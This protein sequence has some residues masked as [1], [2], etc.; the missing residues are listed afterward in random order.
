MRRLGFL[1]TAL[2]TLAVAARAQEPLPGTS[3]LTL[4]GDLSAQMVAGI[5]RF[6]ENQTAA[7]A[8]ERASFWHRDLSSREAY[9]KSVAPNRERLRT[10]IGAVDAR[11]PVRAL[12]FVGDKIGRA[13]V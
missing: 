7:A 2:S 3:P 9:E 11:L 12:E 8:T 1:F 6:L 4:T 10:I 13:H 5:G